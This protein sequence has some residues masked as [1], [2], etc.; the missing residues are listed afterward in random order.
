MI[1]GNGCLP[2]PTFWSLKMSSVIRVMHFSDTHF[3]VENYGRLDPS[4]GISTRLTDFRRTL[5]KAIEIALSR[6][7]Q[8]AV[9]AGDA[10]KNRDPSQTH[11]REFSS[12]IR[13]LTD[14]GVP[15]VMVTGNH[16]M[17]N[18]RGRAHAIEI[19]RTLGVS[20]VHIIQQPEV[21]LIETTGG[22][23]QIAGL[24]FFMKGS[25]LTREES[26]G[27]TLTEVKEIIEQRYR[28]AL[29]ALASECDLFLPTILL[30]HFWVAGS[31]LS[32]WQQ[33]YFNVNEPQVAVRDLT[34]PEFDYV[35]LGHIHRHQDLNRGHTPPIVYSGSPDRIDFGERNEPK[36]FVMVELQK[37]R[38]DYE[39]IEIPDV[40]A[41][42]DIQVDANT[43]TPT[44]TI[45]NEIAK[46]N[47]KNS[48][49]R[50]TYRIN[51]ANL[52]LV[53]EKEI[54]EALMQAF[55]IVSIRPEVQRDQITRSKFL[56]E[57]L[58]PRSALEHYLDQSDKLRP[59]KAELLEY[60]EPLLE[61]LM[62]EESR[63]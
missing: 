2:R 15:V 30:G 18:V 62:K 46:Y 17:P 34:R 47:L 60:A 56:T 16:D 36:G 23:V 7:V 43:D 61:Q 22:T 40:R 27:K 59:R 38:A 54:R 51:H 31:V 13:L 4:T 50:L 11:Q 55:Y 49:V 44:E 37:G 24:P 26:Y 14:Q 20:N 48:I 10:Y 42:H 25:V 9:F 1:F 19:Y 5:T 6:G 3:G 63:Q 21:C 57:S 12:C 32:S 8:L 29:N 39:F 41:F 33:S 58:D 53:R 45:L 52:P 28:D 35:A